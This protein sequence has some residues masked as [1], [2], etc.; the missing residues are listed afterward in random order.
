M[1]LFKE[2]YTST[3]VSV[4]HR[5]HFC[6]IRHGFCFLFENGI[7]IVYLIPSRHLHTILGSV[8]WSNVAWFKVHSLVSETQPTKATYWYTHATF[9]QE[10]LKLAEKSFHVLTVIHQHVQQL[11]THSDS[12]FKNQ[13][14]IVLVHGKFADLE[15]KLFMYKTYKA[16][17]GLQPHHVFQHATKSVT[18]MF[19]EN[20]QNCF[21]VTL[22]RWIAWNFA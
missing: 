6:I 21:R 20:L 3:T 22:S 11:R 9:Q 1:G 15:G 7:K 16:Y 2:V 14:Q 4:V 17:P 12:S 19:N 10:H 18:S 5:G 13:G 8:K